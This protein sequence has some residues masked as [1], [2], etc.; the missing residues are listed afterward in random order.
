MSCRKD[1]LFSAWLPR[2]VWRLPDAKR[3]GLTK[4][5]AMRSLVEM[6]QPKAKPSIDEIRA[7]LQAHDKALNDKNLDAIM[8]TFSTAPTTVVLGT[9]AGERWMGS[10]EIRGAYTEIVK[11]YDA[12]TLETNC[13]TWKTGGSD[14]DGTMAWIA[15]TCDCKDSLNGK[16]RTYQLNVSATVEKQDGA[17]K[18]VSLHMSNSPAPGPP[19]K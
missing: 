5:T 18:F 15:A 13:A 6:R 19:T 10:Q 7:V 8:A 9:G 16:P 12:G 2:W 17:W 1:F 11:D 4:V 3:V 14:N